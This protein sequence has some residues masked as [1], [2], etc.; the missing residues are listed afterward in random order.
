MLHREYIVTFGATKLVRNPNPPRISAKW[1]ED[2]SENMRL[3]T[4]YIYED[5]KRHRRIL[6]GPI[7]K[8]EYFK[9]KL[10]GIL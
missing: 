1:E 3:Y 4:I 2:S 8:K 7:S 9:R 6:D 5:G 10:A